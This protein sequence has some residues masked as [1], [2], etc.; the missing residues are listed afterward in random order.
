[1]PSENFG[2]GYEELLDCDFNAVNIRDEGIRAFLAV[3]L[4]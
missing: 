3:G 2:L 1:M 4:R